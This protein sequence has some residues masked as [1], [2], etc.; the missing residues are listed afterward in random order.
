MN[1]IVTWFYVL[2]LVKYFIYI[3]SVISVCIFYYTY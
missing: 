3:I 2:W 1:I